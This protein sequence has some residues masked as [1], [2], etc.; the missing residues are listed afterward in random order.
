MDIGTGG[1]FASSARDLDIFMRAL[2]EGDLLTDDSL[3][4]MATVG[5]QVFGIDYGLGLGILYPPE[6]G[7]QPIYGHWGTFGW[8]AGAFYDPQPHRT[9]VVLGRH[10]LPIVWEAAAWA[11]G[12]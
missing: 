12:Q 2:F 5:S 9:I 1:G 3:N 11:D 10:L 4:E 8:E 6:G 7:D